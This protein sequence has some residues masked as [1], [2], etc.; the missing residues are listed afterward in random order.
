MLQYWNAR[1]LKNSSWKTAPRKFGPKEKYPPENYHPENCPQEN[2]LSE[3]THK[4]ERAHTH[5]H[6][7]TYIH[8]HTQKK[9]T[10]ILFVSN[11]IFIEI[12]DR[13]LKFISLNIFWFLITI[14][15]FN[16]FVIVY[17]LMRDQECY[18]AIEPNKRRRF[19]MLWNILLVKLLSILIIVSLN[20]RGL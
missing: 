16:F 13:K 5:T 19:L 8:K 9:K 6:T 17:F 1:P 11:F 2:W 12:F 7:H 3:N 4:R 10:W 18:H 14:C 20:F 15:S